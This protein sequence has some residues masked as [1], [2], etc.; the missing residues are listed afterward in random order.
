M[1][2]ADSEQLLPEL[3]KKL[4]QWLGQEPL[5]TL[6][7]VAEAKLKQFAVAALQQAI[8]AKDHL[9]K[10]EQANESLRQAQRY[11]DF[12]EIL[13]DIVERPIEKPFEVIKL[14]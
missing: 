8:E 13:K 12:L 9:P 3:E 5:R 7:R 14:Y 11:Q 2:K 10:L 4:R 6:N 1:I